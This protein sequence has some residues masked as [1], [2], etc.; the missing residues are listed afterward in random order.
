M[1]RIE[2]ENNDLGLHIMRLSGVLDGLT[3]LDL[4]KSFNQSIEKD[5]K[6]IVLDMNEGLQAGDGVDRDADIR[7]C[8]FFR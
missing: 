4:L 3:Y 1:L 5:A 7:R 2:V 8:R 6:R